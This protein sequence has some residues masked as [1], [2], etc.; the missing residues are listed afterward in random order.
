MF[1]NTIPLMAKLQ[2]AYA[3]VPKSITTATM[4]IQTLMMQQNTV[5]YYAKTSY[6]AFE[7]KAISCARNLYAMQK[8]ARLKS[9]FSRNIKIYILDSH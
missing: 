8:I 1:L 9:Q 5:H 6:S 4:K 3:F 2:T 7:S